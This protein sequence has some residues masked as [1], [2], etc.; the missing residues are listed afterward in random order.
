M[1]VALSSKPNKL[2]TNLRDR[3]KKGDTSKNPGRNLNA[4]VPDIFIPGLVEARN[5]RMM[6][7][8]DRITAEFPKKGRVPV[9][10]FLKRLVRFE[11]IFIGFIKG[12]KKSR[13]VEAV[14]RILV[15]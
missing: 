2:D 5:A 6:N 11:T 1:T 7:I 15:V 12:S 13:T 4:E 8:F 14:F 9:Y 10:L 3:T